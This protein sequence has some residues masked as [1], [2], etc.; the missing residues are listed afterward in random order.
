MICFEMI[1]SHDIVHQRHVKIKDLISLLKV[2]LPAALKYSKK[3]L[4]FIIL[5]T[6]CDDDSL[7]KQFLKQWI[8]FEINYCV[9]ITYT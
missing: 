7:I 8:N 2:L 4:I 9:C 6:F 5:L 1:S 3:K